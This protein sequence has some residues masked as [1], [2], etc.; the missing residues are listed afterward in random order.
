MMTKA[1]QQRPDYDDA[2]A[3]MNLLYR[4]RED[5]ECDDP[6]A[7]KADREAADAWVD[8]TIKTKRKAKPDAKQ[9]NE[10]VR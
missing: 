3:Y 1:I 6:T 5:M 8:K 10:S 9:S 7:A 2:M 4:E